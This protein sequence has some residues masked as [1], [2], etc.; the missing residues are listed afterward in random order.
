MVLGRYLDW[1]PLKSQ[2]NRCMEPSGPNLCQWG[3]GNAATVLTSSQISIANGSFFAVFFASSHVN[4]CRSM[5]LEGAA[6][7]FQTILGETFVRV[8]RS[9]QEVFIRKKLLWDSERISAFAGL[10]VN[11]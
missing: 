1:T 2:R 4:F 10:T 6:A 9:K 3:R 7:L 11:L 8:G 5:D